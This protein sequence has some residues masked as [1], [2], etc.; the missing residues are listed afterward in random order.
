MFFKNKPEVTN[1]TTKEKNQGMRLKNSQGYRRGID[2]S[3][4]IGICSDQ[5]THY[6][7]VAVS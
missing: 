2:P 3:M 6:T 5:P 4:G 7:A 1:P